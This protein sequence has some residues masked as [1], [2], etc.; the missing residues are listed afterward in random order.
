MKNNQEINKKQSWS[1]RKSTKG[2]ASALLGFTILTSGLAINPEMVE[3]STI[4]KVEQGQLMDQER[5]TFFINPQF[6]EKPEITI[7]E[8]NA[9]LVRAKYEL[10]K[11]NVFGDENDKRSIT[12]VRRYEKL[13]SGLD[14]NTVEWS[15]K[16]SMAGG[17]ATTVIIKDVSKENLDKLKVNVLYKNAG[18]YNGEPIDIQ[19]TFKEITNYNLKAAN[20]SDKEFDYSKLQINDVLY[21]GWWFAGIEDYKIDLKIL[22]KQGNPIDPK[23]SAYLSTNSLNGYLERVTYDQVNPS[24]EFSQYL[25]D[26]PN[27][28]QFVT[29]DTIIEQAEYKGETINRGSNNDFTDSFGPT[30]NR[31]TV[32]YQLSGENHEFFLGHQ[33][34]GTAWF[35]F[36]SSTLFDSLPIQPS[37]TVSDSDETDVVEASSNRG[38]ILTYAISQPVGTKGVDVNQTYG[39]MSFKDTLDEKLKFVEGSGLLRDSDGNVY[40]N[41]GTTTYDEKT[42]TVMFDVSKEFLEEMALE[43]ETYVFEFKGE[44]LYDAPTEDITN[45]AEVHINNNPYVTNDTLSHLPEVTD[46]NIDKFIIDPDGNDVTENYVDVGTQFQYR[47]SGVY[48]NNKLGKVQGI[49]DDVPDALHIEDVRIYDENNTDITE[50]GTLEIDNEQEK[51]K[52]TANDSKLVFGKTIYAI[53]TV[54]VKDTINFAEYEENGNYVFKNTA[55]LFVDDETI[56][57]KEVKSILEKVESAISKGIVDEDTLIEENEVSINQ[58]FEYQVDTTFANESVPAAL[59]LKDSVPQG[60]NLDSV[61]ITDESG[62]DV[63]EQGVLELDEEKE[64]FKWTANTAS[65]FVGKTV[66]AKIQVTVKDDYTFTEYLKDDHFEFENT[67]QQFTQNE[68]GNEETTDS[69]TVVSKLMKVDNSLTKVIVD[70]EGNEV[71]ENEVERGETYKYRISQVVSNEQNIESLTFTDDLEDVLDVVETNV[72]VLDPSSTIDEKAEED[73]TTENE[74]ITETESGEKSEVEESTEEASTETVEDESEVESVDIT[75][76]DVNVTDDTKIVSWETEG[77]LNELKG[78]T[79]VTEID[80]QIPED[81]EISELPTE[82]DKHVIL[83]TATS[84]VNKTELSS[85]EVKTLVPQDEEEP[86]VETAEEPNAPEEEQEAPN[87]NPEQVKEGWLPHTGTEVN[88]AIIFGGMSLL[89]AAGYALYRIRKSQS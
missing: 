69:N 41:A 58:T 76:V 86:I 20:G 49:I 75:Q 4:E 54:T 60:F 46:A 28:K 24:F 26:N 13:D 83:N 43:G 38:E 33:N 30:Y 67:A 81:A 10:S 19:V 77:N 68:E 29:T 12:Q 5:N 55:Q 82:D 3:A 88:Y 74:S 48:P 39:Q 40:E 25:N 8:G 34:Y 59:G 31:A 87:K 73:E 70:K 66:S 6:T 78:Q 63:T 71:S 27:I 56:D 32:S 7:E 21:A 62:N 2:I 35:S 53:P 80:V 44:V 85:N 9:E 14:P 18:H 11:E 64:S 45:T 1:L 15:A 52:W 16:E 23:G 51:F 17:G 72:Y 36:A 84:T 89:A 22:D 79:I 65:Q 37:K 50:Q 47:I 57:S 42:R 61:V